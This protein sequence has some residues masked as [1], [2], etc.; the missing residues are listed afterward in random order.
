MTSASI[1]A[2]EVMA[3]WAAFTEPLEG[4]ESGMYLD[5]EGYV[6]TGLGCLLASASDA[7]GLVWYTAA[8]VPATHDQIVAEWWRV[9]GM[10]A[11]HAAHYYLSPTGLHLLNDAIDALAISRLEADGAILAA[12][13]PGFAGFPWKVQMGL[14]G[15]AWAVGAGD[16][17][18]GLTGPAWPNLHEAVAAGDWARAAKE[19][20]L[21]GNPKR[22]AATAALFLAAAAE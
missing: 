20:A 21:R 17:D 14:L 9:H 15:D 3:G 5:D 11:D 1:I 18:E 19:C 22:S 8:G 4:R 12:F 2:P 6:T 10:E 16:E 7:A 13:W